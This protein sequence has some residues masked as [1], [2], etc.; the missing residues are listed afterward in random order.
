MNLSQYAK[1]AKLDKKKE[2]EKVIYIAFF[3]Q[4]FQND[5]KFS[6]DDVLSWFD[7][8]DYATPNK[9]RLK[10]SISNSSRI[11]KKE[12]DSFRLHS[13]V[14]SNLQFQF[15]DLTSK[16]EE[17][18]ADDL[19]ISATLYTNTRGYIE[20]LC[21]QINASYVYNIFDGCAVLMRRLLE[22]LL[23]LSYKHLNIDSEIKDTSGSYKMFEAII[24]NAITNNNLSL[25]RN[26]KPHLN[27]FRTVGNFSAHKIEYNATKKDIDNIKIEYRATIEELLYKSGIKK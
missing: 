5:F 10:T 21:K 11:V 20:S 3:F 9:T 14:F 4:N 22:I 7:K 6:I 13:T 15:P 12:K 2:I 23:I 26:T 17:V 25:S 8:L 27:D 24:N 19:I 16:S 1:I 18:I